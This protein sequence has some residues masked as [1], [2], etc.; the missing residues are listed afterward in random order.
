MFY[1]QFIT[2]PLSLEVLQRLQ[3]IVRVRR[4][5]SDEPDIEIVGMVVWGGYG[6]VCGGYGPVWCWEIIAV[7]SFGTLF[8]YYMMGVGNKHCVIILLYCYSW[9]GGEG[10]IFH[11]IICGFRGGG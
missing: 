6:A 4:C 2:S 7:C 10:G 8:L 3:K 9:D 1:T 5:A 11:F